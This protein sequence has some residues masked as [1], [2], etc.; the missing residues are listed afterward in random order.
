MFYIFLLVTS[1]TRTVH[2]KLHWVLKI[3]TSKCKP[4]KLAVRGTVLHVI[5]GGKLC[6]FLRTLDDMQ[7]EKLVALV[8]GDVEAMAMVVVDVVVV[9]KTEEDSAAR[10]W[11]WWWWPGTQR[12]QI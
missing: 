6:R 9:D 3:S 12:L 11:M 4:A 10:R 5:E 1:T 7:I 2:Q 8:V